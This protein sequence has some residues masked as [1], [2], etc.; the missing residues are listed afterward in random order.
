MLYILN[1]IMTDNDLYNKLSVNATHKLE[2]LMEVNFVRESLQI[3][4]QK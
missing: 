3:I 2:Q 1:K 4:N